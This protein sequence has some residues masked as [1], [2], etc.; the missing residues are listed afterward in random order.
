MMVFLVEFQKGALIAG[1]A[2]KQ[3]A[4]GPAFLYL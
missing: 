2:L 1:A 3:G 4:S